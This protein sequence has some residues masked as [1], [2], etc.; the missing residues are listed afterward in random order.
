MQASKKRAS[1]GHFGGDHPRQRVLS[2]KKIQVVKSPQTTSPTVEARL[3]TSK[4]RH[5]NK[6]RLPE[7]RLFA[8][9][10]LHTPEKTGKIETKHM[11]IS[12]F[13]VILM[14]GGFTEVVARKQKE[15]RFSL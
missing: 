5:Y 4:T 9:K 12:P 14:V 15:A 7:K 11:K 6:K 8:R 1:Q 10:L 3:T 2:P 13:S